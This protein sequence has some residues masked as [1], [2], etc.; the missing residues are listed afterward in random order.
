[1]CILTTQF[2]PQFVVRAFGHAGR[3]RPCTQWPPPLGEAKWSGSAVHPAHSFSTWARAV[4]AV[5]NPVTTV[6]SWMVIISNFRRF[7]SASFVDGSTIAGGGP[8]FQ[9]RCGLN[10]RWRDIEEAGG[11]PF[12]FPQ[13]G[14]PHG[15]GHRG[16]RVD[17]SPSRAAPIFR[18]DK[19]R[20]RTKKGVGANPLILLNPMFQVLKHRVSGLETTCSKNTVV[21]DQKKFYRLL[22]SGYGAFSIRNTVF[23]EGG[24][25]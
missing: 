19:A 17:G 25:I 1:M 4:S 8:T 12:R 10:S 7:I 14:R 13:G 2:A 3:S 6:N 18:R 15:R 11:R 23:Q 21:F 9:R 16:N 5:M 24:Q 22:L 20:R